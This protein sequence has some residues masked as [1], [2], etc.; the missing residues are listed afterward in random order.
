MKNNS[1]IVIDVDKY[2]QI[3]HNFHRIPEIGFKEHKTSVYILQTLRTV[4]KFEKL[5]KITKVGG[6]GFFIDIQGTNEQIKSKSQLIAIRADID[7]LPLTEQTG[8]DYKS[9]HE[10]MAHA[11]GHDGHSTILIA[12]IEYY[13]NNIDKVPSNFCTRFIFQP[14]EESKGGAISMIEGGCLEGVEEIYG[15][16]NTTNFKLGEIGLMEGAMMASIVL[17]YITI[18]G[19]GGHGST[20]HKCN[21]PISIG[22]LIIQLLN[23]ITSQ[24]IDSKERCVVTVGSFRSGEAHN[25]IPEKAVIK[26]TFRSF[27][28]ENTDNLIKKISWI[29]EG[30]E[31]L[32]NAESIKVDFDTKTGDVTFNHKNPTA[33]V[34]KVAS[35]YFIVSSKGLPVM[36]SED[37]SFYQNKIPGC[38]FYLGGGDETHDK[39][40]H[41]PYFDFNDKSIPIGVEMFIRIIEEKSSCNLIN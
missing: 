32:Y 39:N 21:N 41:S 25:V 37:F 13:L 34:N 35:E 30:A 11:C 9:T 4:P 18:T 10:G 2:I 1:N 8:L 36:G 12:T 5:S 26:G 31:K 7:A 33:V 6:T 15:L 16:H 14:A 40:I 27:S 38:F 23:Q 28:H 3:R 22:S 29:C 17:F 24:Q 20:P 19:T